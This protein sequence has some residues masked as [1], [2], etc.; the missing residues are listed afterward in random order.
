[1]LNNRQLFAEDD[2]YVIPILKFKRESSDTPAQITLT[3]RA[4]EI[5][6]LAIVSLLFMEKNKRGRPDGSR[7]RWMDGTNTAATFLNAVF[8]AAVRSGASM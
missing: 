1:M 4:M 7:G 6:D 5:Q 8:T 3:A 2:K